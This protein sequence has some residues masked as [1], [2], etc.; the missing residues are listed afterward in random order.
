MFGLKREKALVGLDIG[1]RSVKAVELFDPKGTLM[2]QTTYDHWKKIQGVMVPELIVTQMQ[3]N[4]EY[5]KETLA[6]NRLAINEHVDERVFSYSPATGTEIL[7]DSTKG[8]EL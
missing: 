4:G 3:G 1:S 5:V 2:T 8:G 6:F 7:K